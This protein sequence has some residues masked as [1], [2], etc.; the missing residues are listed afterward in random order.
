MLVNLSGVTALGCDQARNT[1]YDD[2]RSTF[3]H[4]S[5][6]NMIFKCSPVMGAGVGCV[7]TSGVVYVKYSPV[8]FYLLPMT[9]LPGAIIGLGLGFGV[10]YVG[11]KTYE[12]CVLRLQHRQNSDPEIAI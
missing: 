5:I 11:I 12:S 10:A 6:C 9:M 7:I 2:L 4:P 1:L 3:D 8:S